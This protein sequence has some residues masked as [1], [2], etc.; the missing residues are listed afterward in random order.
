MKKGEQTVDMKNKCTA[1]TF[2]CF[3]PLSMFINLLVGIFLSTCGHQRVAEQDPRGTP[4]L[5]IEHIAYERASSVFNDNFGRP[6]I[7]NAKL[8]TFTITVANRGTR[9][10]EG[11]LS[12]SNTRTDLGVYDN[13]HHISQEPIHLAVGDRI[14][15]T[16]SDA[17]DYSVTWVSFRLDVELIEGENTIPVVS[18]HLDK[19]IKEIRLPDR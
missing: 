1:R 3:S 7:M 9:D 12:I 5:V 18:E 4:E 15:I 8:F 6:A 10:F 19:N 11:F 14:Q 17:F 16:T 2:R 13:T